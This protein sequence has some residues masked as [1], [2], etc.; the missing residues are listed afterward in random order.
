[1]SRSL[2]EDVLGRDMTREVWSGNYE[3]VLPISIQEFD[4]SAVLP[5]VFY[6][7]RYGYR[8]G[9]GEFLAKFADPQGKPPATRRSATVERIAECLCQ[10]SE[11]DGF[12][13]EAEQAILGDLLLCYCVENSRRALGRKEQVQRV[14]PAHYMSAWV[15][16]PDSVVH[17][18]YVPEMV[19]AMLANQEGDVVRQNAVEDR[20]WFA[21]GRGFENNVL[22]QAF[23]N[24]VRIEGELASLR[25]D[26]FNEQARVGIDELLMIRLAQQLG[27]AP[28]RIRQGQGGSVVSNQRP[29]AEQAA[30]HFSEDI[31]RFVRSYAGTMPRQAFVVTL[32]SCVAVGL[33]TILNSVVEIMLEWAHTGQVRNSREQQPLPLFVDASNGTNSPLRSIAEQSFD[34]LMR[35]VERFPVILMGAR[36]LDWQVR[37][38]KRLRANARSTTPYAT[39]W[40]GLLGDVLHRRHTESEWVHRDLDQK[41]S[42]LADKLRD[43]APEVQKLLEDDKGYPNPVWRL[44]EALTLLRGR[45]NAQTKLVG[46][47]DSCLLSG[48]PNGL[49]V[50]RQGRQADP[51]TVRKT[52][53]LRSL[54][55][56]D[57]VLDYL[58]HVSLLP[59]GGGKGL[60]PLS[61]REF[62]GTIRERY[63]F[64]VD[65]P[66]IGVSVSND[67]LQANRMIL[68]RRLRDLGLLAGVNDAEAMKRLKPRFAPREGDTNAADQTS[69][70][71]PQPSV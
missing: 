20:T 55:F 19:V 12:R 70:V 53:E 60:R 4:L 43:E 8:R 23:H 69:C 63:G 1:M 17:L 16:L 45:K 46:C 15:D 48:R 28:D 33:T 32:E 34:D 42:A 44:A 30:R 59:S 65:Q 22:L 47:M 21:V 24:G 61:F 9:K 64:Y 26:K 49:A 71:A 14:A 18:R 6:M 27:E 62:L 57:T 37:Y 67:L 11:F 40:L 7:F 38:D 3:K 56:S 68:E 25:S 50:S 66:P 54:V 29:I 36:L 35:R 58:V 13:G 31:R 10:S 5:A 39:E 2:V 52:R 51:S 41:A